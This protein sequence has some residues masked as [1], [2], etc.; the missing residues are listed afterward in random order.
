MKIFFIAFAAE[1][2]PIDLKNNFRP[3]RGSRIKAGCRPTAKQTKGPS[4]SETKKRPR[5]RSLL[6]VDR[7]FNTP[8]LLQPRMQKINILHFQTDA[9]LFIFCP[10]SVPGTTTNYYPYFFQK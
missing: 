10:V 2:T 1:L 6:V 8:D 9:I 4:L 5:K 3:Q 7:G